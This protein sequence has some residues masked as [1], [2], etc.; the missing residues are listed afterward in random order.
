MSR[1]LAIGAAVLV[2]GSIILASKATF[3]EPPAGVTHPWEKAQAVLAATE[4]DIQKG[5]GI[6][7]VKAHVR[8]LEQVLADANQSFGPPASKDGT[9]YVLVDG[10]AS[11][12]VAMAAAAA[13]RG[14]G[15]RKVVSV[16]NPYPRI[17]FFLGS[18]Y[19][20]IGKPGD[21][22]RVLDAG[23]ALPRVE[24]VANESEPFLISERGAALNALRRFPEALANF[25]AG[26]KLGGLE[27]QYRARFLRG[28][29]FALTELG[30]LDEGEA[31]YR[32][33]L[34]I[35]PNSSVALREL[36]YI[37]R[38]RAGGPATAVKLTMPNAPNP[39]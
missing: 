9:T 3:A 33:S 5:G 2:G 32:D 8:D 21:A 13:D 6:M 11:A 39:K 10:P 25:Q 23:L 29:G 16:S 30:R 19:D 15:G 7:P 20:E 28:R 34:K 12:L 24:G 37:A 17:S 26:L 38:L 27:D 31:S 18:Y 14:A 22:V 4:A 36:Q 1:C 35:E